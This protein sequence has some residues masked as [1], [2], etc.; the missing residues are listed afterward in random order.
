MCVVH[1]GSLAVTEDLYCGRRSHQARFKRDAIL[2]RLLCRM[3]QA[4]CRAG[5]CPS[6]RSTQEASS[7]KVARFIRRGPLDDLVVAQPVGVGQA[8]G[9]GDV[10]RKGVEQRGAFDIQFMGTGAPA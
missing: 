8:D 2:F 6:L 1:G 10:V 7:R 9:L 3:P 4:A 5:S